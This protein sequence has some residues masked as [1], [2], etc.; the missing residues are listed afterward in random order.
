M[1]LLN[2][3]AHTLNIPSLVPLR[4]FSVGSVTLSR[5]KKQLIDLSIPSLLKQINQRKKLRRKALD[6]LVNLTDEEAALLENTWE[7]WARDD[8]LIPAPKDEYLDAW[9]TWLIMAGRGWGKTQTGA[10]SIRKLVEQHGYHRIAIIG[11]N[12]A[13]VRDVMIE[14][15]SGLLQSSPPWFK[16][17][18]IPSQRKVI[19]PNGAVG[20]CFSAEEPESLR[21]PQFDAA[22]L[23]E[24]AKWRYATEAFDQ[25]QFGLRLGRRPIQIITTTPRPVEILKQI[26]KLKSTFITKGKTYDNLSNLAPSFRETIVGRYEGT[27]LGRQELDAELLDDNPD[28]LWNHK[29]IDKHRLKD[30]DDYELERTVVAVDPPATTS[31]RCGIVAAGQSGNHAVV[32]EDASIEHRSPSEW[33][34]TAV[35][36]YHKYDAD[37]I[38]A[39]VNQGGDMVKQIIRQIDPNVPVVTVRAY[40]GK[41]LRAEPVAGLYEQG[42]VHHLGVFAEL[43]DQ[44]VQLTPENLAKGKSPDNLDAMVWAIT[45]LMLKK[46]N[47]PRVRTL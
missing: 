17:K 44:M 39:E 34:G 14:G 29:G 20:L 13:E 12:A 36:I 11:G 26:I 1:P 24:L 45:E 28:A 21:G 33:A 10:Q 27:R 15:P 9:A 19:W 25:L 2:Q 6:V 18:Y 8:Q 47:K 7:F 30:L 37:A 31:G 42:R 41:W 43:E 38:V 22:W 35:S 3:P 32:L 5:S 46:R 40:R 16:P 4:D 23:D